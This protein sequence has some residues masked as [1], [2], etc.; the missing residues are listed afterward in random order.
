MPVLLSAR[1]E[2]VIAQLRAC[3]EGYKK[4]G[5]CGKRQAVLFFNNGRRRMVIKKLG[6]LGGFI[7]IE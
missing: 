4:L 3:H 2:M 1:G 7:I 5:N 6:D